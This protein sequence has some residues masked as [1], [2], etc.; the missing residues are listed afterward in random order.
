MNITDFSF[1]SGS[2]MA[3]QGT[4]PSPQIEGGEPSII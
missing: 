1:V 4:A 3:Q 2:I